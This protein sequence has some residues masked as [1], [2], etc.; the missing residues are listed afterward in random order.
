MKLWLKGFKTFD[1]L[2]LTLKPLTVLIGPPASG[3]SNLLEALALLG[4]PHKILMLKKTGSTVTRAASVK[5]SPPSRHSFAFRT[6]WK[7]S[8]GSTTGSQQS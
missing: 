5:Q 4:L 6:R 3:K 2:S 7:Y 1:Q 8:P